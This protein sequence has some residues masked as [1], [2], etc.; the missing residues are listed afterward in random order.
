MN[1]KIQSVTLVTAGTRV[2][3]STST[4][5]WRAVTVRARPSNGSMTYVGSSD[6]AA[7]TGIQLDAGDTFTFGSEERTHSGISLASFYMDGDLAG[8]IVDYWAHN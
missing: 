5:P 6:V 4:A 7:G 3:F 8:D 1:H 2:R